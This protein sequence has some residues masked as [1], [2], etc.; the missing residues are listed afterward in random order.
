MK[1]LVT[2]AAGF[3]GSHL[4]EALLGQ[5]HE[6]VGIDCFTD[7]YSRALKERN[8]EVARGRPGFRFREADLNELEL[9]PL[10]ESMDG[11][12]HLAA[13]AGVRASW[14]KSFQAYIDCNIRATQ[15]LLEAIKDNGGPRLVFAS[16]SSIYGKTDELPTKETSAKRPLSPYGA[17]KLACEALCGLY[18]M[19]FGLDV[20]SL[21][22]FTVY[23][24]RQRPDMAFHR[25]FRAVLM[26][27][28]ITIYGDGN[29]TRDFTYVSD[30]VAGTQ[31]AMERGVA[32][33]AYN[34]GGGHRRALRDV[35]KKIF[36][37][38]GKETDLVYEPAQKG[39]VPDTY[40]DTS[41]AKKDTGFAPRADLE[42]GLA[43]EYEWIR[44]LYSGE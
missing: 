4:C 28:R 29:Q 33:S 7:Y 11:V 23:G 36:E 20:N 40:A 26:G 2:G 24:P 5:G 3:I 32:G 17:T 34:L 41:L 15:R 35:I 21:R 8:L 37:V 18:H 12:F 6:V 42:E 30:I 22:Y 38:A 16:T 13:Q 1:Y 39:D 27:E 25:F 44:S 14:G 31:A 43:A 19:N 10:L 9:L